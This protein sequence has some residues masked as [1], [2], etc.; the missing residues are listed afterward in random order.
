MPNGVRYALGVGRGNATLLEPASSH[1]T[2]PKTRGRPQVG[3][4]LCFWIEDSY[5]F[6]ILSFKIFN[7]EN[8][9][10]H[11]AIL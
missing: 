5:V 4:T 3:C 7:S 1:E 2:A 9:A 6:L 10:A 8:G 11:K